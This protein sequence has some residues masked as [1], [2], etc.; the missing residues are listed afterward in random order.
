MSATRITPP[1]IFPRVT[2]MRFLIKK[3]L[4][5]RLLNNTSL[6]VKIVVADNTVGLF[7]SKIPSGIKYILAIE[8]SKPQATNAL[9]GNT[10]ANILSTTFLP[11]KQSQTARHTRALQS[12]PLTN[13][14]IKPK[15]TFALAIKTAL[16]PTKY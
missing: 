13:A 8:C 14:S 5:V 15:L 9:T 12:I 2:G 1:M 10:M 6:S 16:A 4:T 7:F 11:E 3:F